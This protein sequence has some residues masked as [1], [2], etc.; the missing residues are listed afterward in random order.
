[1]GVSRSAP[2]KVL[3][4]NP[5]ITQIRIESRSADPIARPAP[6]RRGILASMPQYLAFGIGIITTT[7]QG[8]EGTITVAGQ[9]VQYSSVDSVLISRFSTCPVCRKSLFPGAPGLVDAPL[10]SAPSAISA[11]QSLLLLTGRSCSHCVQN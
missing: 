5:Q 6:A 1:L 7:A 10:V 3:N 4:S 11:V 2:G 8:H 9:Y